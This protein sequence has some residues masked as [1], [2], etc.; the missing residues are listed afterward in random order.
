[1]HFFVVVVLVMLLPYTAHAGLARIIDTVEFEGA[2][3]LATAPQ[4][5]NTGVRSEVTVIAGDE[6]TFKTIGVVNGLFFERALLPL[7]QAVATP[8]TIDVRTEGTFDNE[9]S[10]AALT[11][12][13]EHPRLWNVVR[14]EEY[15][16]G[17][18]WRVR[19]PSIHIMWTMPP[20]LVPQ[21][22]RKT[23]S[24]V[25]PLRSRYTVQAPC[26]VTT[27]LVSVGGSPLVSG[28]GIVVPS[29]EGGGTIEI[30]H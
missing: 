29:G 2:L 17:T 11:P 1:M 12:D 19:H 13:L 26:I 23:C 18:L 27:V 14:A 5:I 10:E 3:F 20:M 9:P 6:I 30:T 7:S 24:V 16:G 4:A 8:P 22:L 15:V 28:A 25:S 21:I